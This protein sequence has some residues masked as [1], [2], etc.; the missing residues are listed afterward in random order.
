MKVV[1]VSYFNSHPFKPYAYKK[2][3]F[4]KLE[5]GDFVVVPVLDSFT[6]G[7]VEFLI[8]SKEYFKNNPNFELKRVC[9]KI[10]LT[11]NI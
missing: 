11:K 9:K 5:K 8:S 1:L 3:L 6:V 2:P 4:M 7:R 10:D